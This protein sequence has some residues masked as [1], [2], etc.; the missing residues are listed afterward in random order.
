[1]RLAVGLG[2]TGSQYARTRHNVGFMVIDRLAEE[3]GASWR[4]DGKFK[5]EIAETDL[6]GEKLILAKP[7][8]MM[9]LSG[10]AAQK[11]VQFYKPDEVWAIFDDLDVPF[12]SLRLRHGGSAGGHNGVKSLIQHIGGE[13]V[14]VRVGISLNDRT[15]EA[16]EDYVLRSF[17]AS[18]QEQL[19]NITLRA[20]EIVREQLELNTAEEATFDLINSK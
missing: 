14:R 20:A 13:F 18:E 12:G 11:I 2:N 7:Q 5:A 15:S 6:G 19:P 1:M 9:N 17:D 16:A 10:E 3:L 8:T 4:T